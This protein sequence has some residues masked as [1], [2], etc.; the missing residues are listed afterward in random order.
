MDNWRQFEER[1]MREILRDQPEP[2]ARSPEERVALRRQVTELKIRLGRY[3]QS[4]QQQQ[5]FQPSH[6]E[7]LK[8][9]TCRLQFLLWQL[10]RFNDLPVEIIVHIFRYAVWSTTNSPEGVLSRFRLTWV[11]RQWR[12]TAINDQ[13]L[14]NTIWFKDAKLGYE[15]SKL[16][17][18][19]AG[20]ATLDLRIE[21]NDKTR[22]TPDRPMTGDDMARILDILMTKASQIR[23]IILVVELWPP[24]LVFLD[25]LHRFS[26][27]LQQL[28]RIEFHRTG[29]PYRWDGPDYPLCNYQHALTLCNGRTQRIN[30]ICMNGIHLDWDKSGLANL[31]DLDLRRMPPELGPSLER[32]RYILESSPNLKKLSLDGAGPIEPT[33]SATCSYPPVFLPKLESLILGDC[34]VTYAIFCA[35]IIHAPNVR[36]V[37]I[38]NL[39]DPDHAPL[40]QALT[41]KF[42]ELL[43]LTLYCLNVQKI[44]LNGR[45]LVQWLL[46]IPKIKFMRVA[47]VTPH[48]LASFFVDGRL[49]IRNDIP[50]HPTPEERE[51]I[52]ADGSP[53]IL[54]PELEAIE[55]QHI[56]VDSVVNFVYGRH[57]FGA[58]LRKLYLHQSWVEKLTAEEKAM[59]QK[60]NYAK[61]FAVVMRPMSMTPVEHSIWTQLRGG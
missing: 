48:L 25:R 57:K 10:F 8:K 41:G 58:P 12:R 11:C 27:Y 50:L 19:R 46:S 44:P 28:E 1:Q 38:L 47:M 3:H 33:G 5:P 59:I 45:I 23:M 4:I 36:E 21:D 34:R 51:A 24:I 32:F 6:Y 20:T 49:H 61:D 17:F 53:I 43:M 2:R 54:C 35:R 42:P 26:R 9:E 15:L 7:A 16:Y 29:R 30:H 40:L 55:V 22:V 14:W 52:L 39:V 31:T 56:D 13:T 18:Q 60:Q 37:T